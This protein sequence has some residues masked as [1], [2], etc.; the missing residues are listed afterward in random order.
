MMRRVFFFCVLLLPIVVVSGLMKGE[1]KTAPASSP[2]GKTIEG[3]SLPDAR[4][5]QPVS[6]ADLKA[7][8]A[9]VVVFLGTACPVNNAY[10]PRLVELHKKYSADGVQFLAINANK[11]DQVNAVA[12]HAR[13]HAIP[14]PVLKDAQG[15]VADLFEARRTPE[16][17]I[18]DGQRKICY[19]GRIDDQ[20]GPDINR[21][22]PTKTELKDALEAVLAGK[23]VGVT[24]TEVAGCLI[25]RP[26]K[27]KDK[28][29]TGVTFTKDISRILQKNC[30]ECHRPGQIGPMP[31]LSYEDAEGW[32]S[33]IRE[34]VAERRM[35]PWYAD[36]KVGHFSNDRSLPKDERDA[37]LA[38][39]DAGC[40]KGDDKDMP[41]RREFAEGWRIGKPDVIF[42]MP[43]PF[44]VPTEKPKYGVPYQYFLV[45][46]NFKEDVWVE[47]AEARPG[48]PEVVHHIIAF[49]LPPLNSKEEVPPGPPVLPKIAP[50][51]GGQRIIPNAEKGTVLCG[52]APGDM[53][54][55]LPPGFARKIPAGSKI[56][57][58]MHYTPNG[59]AQTDRSSVGLIFAKKPPQHR[60]LSI[61]VMQ[62]RL[63][64]PPGEAN[65]HTEAWGPFDMATK[66]PGFLED[67]IVLGFMPHMH[68]RG[69][70]FFIEAVYPDGK[71]EAIL[72]VP[73]FNFG[74]QNIYRYAEP[75]KMPKG[76]LIHC[77]AHFDNSA[78]NANN[79][80]PTVKVQWGDQTWQEMM[81]GWMD[82]AYGL[83][84]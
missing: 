70:D 57:F 71:K 3:F 72:N 53:P 12:E 46:T 78:G 73:R 74:W 38:W 18:L 62:H 9:V 16:A 76:T 11:I 10:L 75:L 51:G 83:K 8:K 39:V 67:A 45:D 54:L 24:E 43:E 49:V 15:Q 65:Y 23:A 6:L 47:R 58:Q 20:F 68:L 82:C 21:P 27:Q 84:P 60:V 56:V 25:T 42:T 81:I 5:Q 31:L 37:V 29:E 59:K 48:A 50:G 55:I 69:K 33:M 36:V 26:A 30:Q 34:V 64:I 61:P 14:F 40:P 35:P 63:D 32:S 19:R 7:S 77:V 13:Q 52:T 4:T 1:E 44:N 28:A 17:F 80:D 2:V 66:Q 79:P 41:P 22:Q